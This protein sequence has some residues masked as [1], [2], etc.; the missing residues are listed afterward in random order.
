[1]MSPG[2]SDPALAHDPAFIGLLAGSYQRLVGES[3]APAGLE[4]VEAAR[5][6]YEEAPFCVLA[7]NTA[8]DPRFVYA[9]RAAQACFGFDWEEMTRLPSRLSAEAPNRAERQHWQRSCLARSTRA[10][11]QSPSCCPAAISIPKC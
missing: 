9:N 5:W 2:P 6:L 3:L 11:E 4:F 8:E 1:M 7:H 10:P